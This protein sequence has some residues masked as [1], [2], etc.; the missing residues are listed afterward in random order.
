VINSWLFGAHAHR[1]L[2]HEFRETATEEAEPGPVS[3]L[4]PPQEA[5]ELE[6][7]FSLFKK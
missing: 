2:H 7:Y 1:K 5:P 4:P 3:I 6:E